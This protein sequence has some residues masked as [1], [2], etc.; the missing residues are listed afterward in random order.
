[1]KISPHSLGGW[2][3]L[4][5]LASALWFAA[6]CFMAFESYKAQRWAI[7]EGGK[8][9]PIVKTESLNVFERL[10]IDEELSCIA[11]DRVQ[12]NVVTKDL[13]AM[14]NGDWVPAMPRADM[15]SV[16]LAIIWKGTLLWFL[17][18]LA[19]YVA[20]VAVL[21]VTKGFKQN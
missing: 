5:L 4:W 1:M 21:W 14:R 11:V 16:I 18:T 12:I 7:A 3:R 10:L 15:G 19:V 9:I 17:P 8:N 6:T 2:H 20:G 13:R